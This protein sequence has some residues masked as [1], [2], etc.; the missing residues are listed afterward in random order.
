MFDVD[1]EGDLSKVIV[2]GDGGGGVGENRID[3]LGDRFRQRQRQR[4]KH[5]GK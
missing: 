1:V 2:E 5:C 4:Q 3:R